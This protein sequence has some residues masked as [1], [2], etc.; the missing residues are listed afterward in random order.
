MYSSSCTS[1]STNLVTFVV[2][3][4]C[5]DII[6]GKG[7]SFILGTKAKER[8]NYGMSKFSTLSEKTRHNIAAYE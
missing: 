5:V 2:Y 1:P 6:C 3:V 7:V 4:M 8:G